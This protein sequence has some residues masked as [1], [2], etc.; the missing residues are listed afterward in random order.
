[1]KT[2][3]KQVRECLIKSTKTLFYKIID[4]AKIS[5]FQRRILVDRF[6]YNKS[7]VQISLENHVSLETVR[8]HIGKA[9]DNIK[10]VIMKWTK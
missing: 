9:Y 5:E 10:G 2:A 4:E 6:V 7:N 1:M 3:R 8:N